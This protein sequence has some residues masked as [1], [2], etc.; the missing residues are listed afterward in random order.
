[1]AVFCCVQIHPNGQWGCNFQFLNGFYGYRTLTTR[2][3]PLRSIANGTRVL[4][5]SVG[6]RK[7]NYS[8]TARDFAT[9]TTTESRVLRDGKRKHAGAPENPVNGT[10]YYYK[11]NA[12]LPFLSRYPYR[13]CRR[14]S[15]TVDERGRRGVRGRKSAIIALK[16]Q[17]DY[18]ATTA[19]VNRKRKIIILIIIKKISITLLFM[20]RA[21][22]F[23]NSVGT[24]DVSRDYRTL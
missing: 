1:M 9:F 17:A 11:D 19:R 24:S 22:C 6:L 3:V 8:T 4:G 20:A 10:L 15:V 21:P 7:Q 23:A 2:T 12:P 18:A 5:T 14:K 16:T 13:S